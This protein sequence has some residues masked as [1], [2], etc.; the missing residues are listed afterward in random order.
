M[1]LAVRPWSFGHRSRIWEQIICSKL[2]GAPAMPSDF[3]EFANRSRNENAI[4]FSRLTDF[5]V[6]E[7]TNDH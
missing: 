6:G 2:P 7:E 4:F 1:R 5:D 3:W